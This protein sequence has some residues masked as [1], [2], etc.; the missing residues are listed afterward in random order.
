MVCTTIRVLGPKWSGS[1]VVI[2]SSAYCITKLIFVRKS[3][4]YHV[5][6]D[7]F[8][9]FALFTIFLALVDLPKLDEGT[10][11]NGYIAYLYNEFIGNIVREVINIFIVTFGMHQIYPSRI[12]VYTLKFMVLLLQY[13]GLSQDHKKN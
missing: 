7:S 5:Q 12:D 1:K 2:L 8:L 6:A 4:F 3:V 9:I 13:T 10:L 11:L